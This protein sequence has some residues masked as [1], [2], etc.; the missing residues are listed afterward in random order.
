MEL[1][2]ACRVRL[3]PHHLL[4]SP[5]IAGAQQ[6]PLWRIPR[7]SAAPLAVARQDDGTLGAHD[8]GRAR[9]IPQQ[10]ARTMRTFPRFARRTQGMRFA[11]LRSEKRGSIVLN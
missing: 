5:G 7:W 4:A 10:H 9:E 6:N 8:A 3:A 11:P 1:A 2:H